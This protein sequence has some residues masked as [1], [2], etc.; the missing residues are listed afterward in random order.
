MK[1]RLD[2]KALIH[3]FFRMNRERGRTFDDS[4]RMKILLPQNVNKMKVYRESLMAYHSGHS[5]AH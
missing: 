4:S 5:H 3:Y 1:N 2:R